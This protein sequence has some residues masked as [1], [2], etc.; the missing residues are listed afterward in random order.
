MADILL[1]ISQDAAE[2]H[3]SPLEALIPQPFRIAGFNSRVER[4][5]C[6]L[7]WSGQNLA[8]KS[9]RSTQ[10]QQLFPQKQISRYRNKEQHRNDAIHGEERGVEFR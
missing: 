7:G 10:A 5:C 1:I 3:D 9:A 4:H 2:D 8:G 6:P